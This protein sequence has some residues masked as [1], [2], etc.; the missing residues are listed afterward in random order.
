MDLFDE[1]KMSLDGSKKLGE[2]E[3]QVLESQLL[4][5]GLSLDKFVYFDEEKLTLMQEYARQ[6]IGNEELVAKLEEAQRKKAS[7]EEVLD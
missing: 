4:S 2:A 7:G 6:G 3:K 1:S 5:G